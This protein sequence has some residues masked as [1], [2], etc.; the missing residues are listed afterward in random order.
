MNP[1]HLLLA[2][3]AAWGINNL[4]SSKHNAGKQKKQEKKTKH[5]KFIDNM[6]RVTAQR[7]QEEK[8]KYQ[9]IHDMRQ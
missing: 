2:S 9:K 3:Q 1:G 7:M 4:F 6:R 8:E 5:K